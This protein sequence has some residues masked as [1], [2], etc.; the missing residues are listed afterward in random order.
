MV[1]VVGNEGARGGRGERAGMNWSCGK[2]G[3]K[4]TAVISTAWYCLLLWQILILGG[5]F[6]LEAAGGGGTT[7]SVRGIFIPFK[8]TYLTVVEGM[9]QFIMYIL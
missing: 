9:H 6:K 3:W 5:T 2:D 1:L 7:Q 8:G 4:G